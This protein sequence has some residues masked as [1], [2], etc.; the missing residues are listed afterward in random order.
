MTFESLPQGIRLAVQAAQEKKAAGITVL[1]LSSASSF[2]DYFVVCTG[3]S[4]PQV[5]AICTEIEEQLYK[6]AGRSPEHREGQRSAEW[7]LLD[8]GGFVVHVF[9]EQARRY[10]DL[11]RLWRSAPKLD[12]QDAAEGPT[13]ADQG[14]RA[15]FGSGHFSEAPRSGRHGSR[16]QP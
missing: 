8:F 11:E 7:A 10:Y 6:H 13:T 16:S 1:D 14:D 5:Q 15:A 4:T 2:T 12:I 3:F 9:S